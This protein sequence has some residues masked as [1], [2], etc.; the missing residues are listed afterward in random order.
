V[1]GAAGERPLF[2][3]EAQCDSVASY[4]RARW[5]MRVADPFARTVRNV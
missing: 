1:F 2:L 3:A 5:V 4:D